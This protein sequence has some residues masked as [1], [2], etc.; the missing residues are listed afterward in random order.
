[1]PRFLVLGIYLI[2]LS[3]D[4]KGAEWIRFLHD[5]SIEDEGDNGVSNFLSLITWRLGFPNSDIKTEMMSPSWNNFL[6]SFLR[7]VVIRSD[8]DE[9]LVISFRSVPCFS[10]AER[11]RKIQERRSFSTSPE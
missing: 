3:G 2:L 9:G 6:Q 8:H 10:V 5:G 11:R 1:M 7:F 4:G